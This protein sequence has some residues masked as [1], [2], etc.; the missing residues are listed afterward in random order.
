MSRL[1][2]I[3]V[4]RSEAK[5]A[6]KMKPSEQDVFVF[7]KDKGS[8]VDSKSL[9]ICGI[10]ALLMIGGIAQANECSEVKGKVLYDKGN[11]RA[12]FQML[13][14]CA[15]KENVAADTLML[16]ATLYENTKVS[17][18]TKEEALRRSWSLKHNAAV[19]GNLGALIEITKAYGQGEEMRRIRPNPERHECLVRV[20]HSAAEHGKFASD[21]VVAC[22]KG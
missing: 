3:N 18:L 4:L 15:R 9:R 1:K 17:K 2:S 22:L 11:M 7:V 14:S 8:I 16:L 6:S 12:A 19:K 21:A 13:E 5:G 10:L 20:V